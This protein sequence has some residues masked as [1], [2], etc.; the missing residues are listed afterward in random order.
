[1]LKKIR[2]SNGRP[3][4]GA[5]TSKR[6]R[7]EILEL[8]EMLSAS[9]LT[10]ND[11]STLS[12]A[13]ASS[14]VASKQDRLN[15]LGTT[16]AGKIDG[17]LW[18]AVA[19]IDQAVQSSSVSLTSNRSA[20]LGVD[21]T[22]IANARVNGAGEILVYA[23]MDDLGTKSLE[24]L[25]SL[26]ASVDATSDVA[27]VAQVWVPYNKVDDLAS[28]SNVKGVELPIEA[29]YRTGAVTSAGDQ[30][31]RA[32]V[33]RSRFTAGIGN[34]VNGSG[35]KIGVISNGVAHLSSSQAS[36]DLP[37][38]TV[39]AAGSGDEGT[40]MLE[41]I[42]DLAPGAQ[43]YFSSAG[44]TTVNM[45]NSITWL[46]NQ[47]VD[48]IVD[49][50]GFYGEQFFTDGAVAQAVQSAVS[51]GVSY[52]SAAGNDAQ[53]H[54][55][56]QWNPVSGFQ[57]FDP[58]AAVDHSLTITT[59]PAGATI[60]AVLQWS[61]AWTTSSNDFDFALVSGSTFITTSNNVQ[62]GSQNP[63]ESLSWTNNTGVPVTVG[64]AIPQFGAVASREFELFVYGNY[65]INGFIE[66]YGS[67]L[68]SVFGHPAVEGV[69]SVGAINTSDSGLDTVAAYSSQGTSTIYTNFATQARTQRQTLDAAG[70]DGVGTRTGQL[71]FFDAVFFGTSAA[72]PH[73]AA[74]AAL[75]LDANPNLTPAQ[76][77]DILRT[78][79]VDLTAYGSGYDNVS[80]AGRAD[81]TG[82]VYK[83]FTPSTP[84]IG[85]GSDTGISSTDRITNDSTPTITGTAP[86]NSFVQ[87]YVDGVANASTQLAGGATTY[88]FPTFS[89][90]NGTRNITIRVAEN[91]SVASSNYSNA[92]GNLPVT[93]DTVAPSA[94][95][96]PDLL[97]ADDTGV[98]STDNITK[99]AAPRFTGTAETGATV[100]LFDG[101]TS[102]PSGPSVSG[103]WTITSS[104]L[105][106]S[107]HAIKARATD[108][109]GNVSADS[110]ALT[111]IVDT[112]APSA[113]SLPDLLSADD[114]GVSNT[115]NITKLAAPRFT[116]TAEVG[117][118][119]TLL[120]GATPLQTGTAAA[121]SW[122]ILSPSLTHSVHSIKARTTDVAGNISA[123]SGSL[124][125]TIDLSAVK[126]TDV[127]LLGTGWTGLGPIS[128]A[129]R[130]VTDAP[131][132]GG[133]QGQQ[134]RP[135]ATQGVNQIQIQFNENIAKRGTNG[136][137]SAVTTSD[138][139]LLLELHQSVRNA[140][141]SVTNAIVSS[142][143]FSYNSGVGTWTFPALPDGK[144]AIHLKSATTGVAGVVDVAG[145]RLD[146]DYVNQTNSTPDNFID[147][148][149]PTS[150][151]VGDNVEGSVNNEFRFH[152]ALLVA[153]YNGDGIVTVADGSGG[154]GNGDGV[155]G[156]AADAS[157]RVSQT[158]A[159]AALPLRK[160]GGAD[161][162]DN[163]KVDSADLAQWRMSFAL[164]GNGDVDGDGDTD[165]NDFLIWQ[166]RLGSQSS[167]Y[168]SPGAGAAQAVVGDFAPW[169]TN[170]IVSGSQSTHTPYSFD[171]VDG[172]GEQLRTVPVGGA[173]TITIVFSENVNVG[174]ES[175]YVFGMRTANVP[176]LAEFSYDSV[177]HAASWRFGTWALGD[178]YLL[179]LPDDVTDVDGNALDGEWTNPAALTTTNAAVSEFPSGDGDPGGWFTF[180]MS[181]LPGDANLD[182]EVNIGDFGIL[183]SNWG[184]AGMLFEDAD[185]NGD[186][187]VNA[188]DF[189]LLS[190]NYLQNLQAVNFIRGD[191][192]SNGVVDG[193]DLTII[194]QNAGMTGATYADGDINED[195]TVNQSDLDLALE[196]YGP[197]WDWYDSVA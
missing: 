104:T 33:V 66:S 65:V 118:T 41:I 94:P 188:N 172:S 136:V 1:M 78:T 20:A 142:T 123:D 69:I 112:I 74:I 183:Q 130:V 4:V 57:D 62:S 163:D 170:V 159:G 160:L 83:A 93:I 171:G 98:S 152:F 100:Q 119:V 32:D 114:T 153:D 121:G 102:L 149:L 189:S 44:G 31:L 122:T 47:G 143:G 38:V 23:R 11:S 85:V 182:G 81:A 131:D 6:P 113:P 29:V 148:P 89:L 39:N 124:P 184:G 76:V 84:Q 117:S 145:L 186:G 185:F 87:I 107:S 51:S 88:S 165:G 101:A 15:S 177:T 79:A 150:F 174:P 133:S 49:D 125:T 181:L 58:G 43:L 26:G 67:L 45:I 30:Q 166:L 63:F 35:V 129:S 197:W 71:G 48:V 157:L 128:F 19:K 180:T 22:N 141:G 167:W 3:V 59:V 5:W 106:N 137:D 139:N 75:M 55:Q 146:G 155:S 108:V 140:N 91:S 187:S 190:Y 36:G 68:D 9:G 110:S 37:A 175:L 80:G 82:S 40:A 60:N 164:S 173:D 61:D 178:H 86:A 54:Y 195:G 90:A 127:K 138:G 64:L 27:G 105:S 10:A 132:H 95:S 72:A 18:D 162:V 191:V 7:F 194:W 12:G 42:H 8:R 192:D 92:S 134:L 151:V 196:Q 176:T 46:I 56:G 147:D 21:L 96:I 77:S 115:D 50:V 13:L 34:L 52:V 161:M 120:D 103:S 169:I 53:L 135:I 179:V 14:V 109:A 111:V 24:A 16:L 158:T 25:T 99:I 28:L 126:A 2:W 17:H 97:A 116:G 154:D 156:G 193:S 70:I 144:Y 73:V 168:V